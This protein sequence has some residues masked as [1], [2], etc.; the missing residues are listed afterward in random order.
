[1]KVG[2]TMLLQSVRARAVVLGQG[3]LQLLIIKKIDK[4]IKISDCIVAFLKA[5]NVQDV[6]V[7]PGDANVHLLDSIGRDEELRF[8][9][10]QME[11]GAVMA[12]EAYAKMKSDLGVVVVS[13][14]AS[15]ANT[16]SGVANAWV[17]STPML[18]ISG[19]ARTEEYSDQVRQLGNKS[20][21][22]IA[23]VKSI[24]KYAVKVTE[25]AEIKYHLEKAACLAKSGRPGPVW[26]DIPIDIQGMTIDEN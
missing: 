22:I 19:Q 5:Q 9:C 25:S 21:N 13:S 11:K 6:F 15:A 16:I 14:G 24:T 4:I 18:V 23:L 26:V 8:I 12:A 1:M 3:P 20:L 17:D 2:D 7:V 10:T